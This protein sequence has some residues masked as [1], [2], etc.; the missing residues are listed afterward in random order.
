MGVDIE[1]INQRIKVADL[2]K[3]YFGVEE[4]TYWKQFSDIE[5]WAFY[6]FWVRKEPFVK[7]R[8]NG[9]ILD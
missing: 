4:I 5:N 1:V 8:G 6:R 2:V 3:K 9:S 7:T